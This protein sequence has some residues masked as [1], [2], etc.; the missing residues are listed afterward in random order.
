MSHLFSDTIDLQAHGYC[1]TFSLDQRPK[2][3]F[4]DH[5]IIKNHKSL[6]GRYWLVSGSSKNRSS[7]EYIANG[8]VQLT[9]RL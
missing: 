6:T 3:L 7:K 9:G 2:V 1:G 4:L 5:C 8:C